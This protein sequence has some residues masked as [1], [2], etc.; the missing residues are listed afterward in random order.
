MNEGFVCC[1]KLTDFIKRVYTKF[2][3]G[4]ANM[5]KDYLMFTNNI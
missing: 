1:F 5:Y 4:R 3:I 2:V